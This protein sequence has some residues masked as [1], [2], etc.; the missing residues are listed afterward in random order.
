MGQKTSYIARSELDELISKLTGERRRIIK[1]FELPTLQFTVRELSV[2][3]GSRHLYVDLPRFAYDLIYYVAVHCHKLVSESPNTSEAIG[4]IKMQKSD[5]QTELGSLT[6]LLHK[7]GI[8]WHIFYREWYKKP[9]IR[10]DPIRYFESIWPRKLMGFADELNESDNLTILYKKIRTLTPRYLKPVSAS[11]RIPHCVNVLF[12]MSLNPFHE[13]RRMYMFCSKM[14]RFAERQEDPLSKDFLLSHLADIKECLA[15]IESLLTKG[16]IFACYQILRKILV[17]TGSFIFTLMYSSTLKGQGGNSI[18]S[19]NEARREF[20]VLVEHFP[21]VWEDVIFD[22]NIVL[23]KG[24]PIAT[25]KKLLCITDLGTFFAVRDKVTSG[26]DLETRDRFLT[27]ILDLMIEDPCNIFDKNVRKECLRIVKQTA[28]N[29]YQ[30]LSL[31]V[32]EPIVV[33]FPPHSSLFE[34]LGLL[35]YLRKVFEILSLSFTNFER[36]FK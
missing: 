11:G 31:S 19:E 20:E 29:T 15:S 18:C 12:T 36:L 33:D 32:H 8:D 9:V 2:K 4:T 16:H 1:M 28:W 24:I 34:F 3:I 35:H 23:I 13:V 30:K 21:K 10:W 25:E 14:L 26:I 7:L 6:L 22:K 5:P 27:E 17:M